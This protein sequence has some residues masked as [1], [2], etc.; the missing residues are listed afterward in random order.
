MNRRLFYEHLIQGVVKLNFQLDPKSFAKHHVEEDK[1]ALAAGVRT[2]IKVL[3]VAADV[4]G[5]IFN[6][7]IPSSAFDLNPVFQHEAFRE[8]IEKFYPL[9]TTIFYKFVLAQPV[10]L[11]VI[12]ADPYK[13]EDFKPRFEEF[14]KILLNFTKHTGAMGK[15]FM[16]TKLSVTGIVLLVFFD[17]NK[18]DKFIAE[19]QSKYKKF[20]FFKKTWLLP[21]V[22]DTTSKRVFSH[23]GLPFLPGVINSGELENQI[24]G[25]HDV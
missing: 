9:T 4:A 20:H 7:N 19:E 18:A 6:L 12:D 22:I 5:T 25:S 3:K 24:F 15:G 2:G 17:R 10:I 23:S 11:A 1:E 13:A 8:D 21:W 14:D 16:K